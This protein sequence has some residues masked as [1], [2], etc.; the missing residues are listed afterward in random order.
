MIHV[1]HAQRVQ[2]KNK[3]NTTKNRKSL[4]ERGRSLGRRVG[5]G[6]RLQYRFHSITR[7]KAFLVPWDTD[8]VAQSI[9][10]ALLARLA[11]AWKH[12]ATV[13]VVV[14]AQSRQN[15]ARGRVAAQLVIG[16]HSTGGVG[17]TGGA[18]LEARLV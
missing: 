16:A 15:L 17:W 2:Q 9:P 3:N 14:H 7:G 1:A 13:E 8:A 6:G 4:N 12:A 10:A 18:E 11:D 5:D